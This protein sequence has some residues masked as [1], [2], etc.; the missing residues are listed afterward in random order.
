M[1][2]AHL[3]N[4]PRREGNTLYFSVAPNEKSNDMASICSRC[5]F[6]KFCFGETFPFKKNAKINLS[7]PFIVKSNFLENESNCGLIPTLAIRKPDTQRVFSP[8]PRY[9][10]T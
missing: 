8:K 5:C 1:A 7:N 3:I 4:Y 6:D 10:L 2:E 9:N